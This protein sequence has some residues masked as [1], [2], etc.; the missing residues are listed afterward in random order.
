M[1]SII[2]INYNDLS[3]LDLAVKSVS[4]QK[5]ATVEH[6]IIDGGSTDGSVAYIQENKHLFSYCISEKD[7]GVYHAMNKGIQAA[8]GDYLF[9]LNAGDRFLNDAILQDFEIAAATKKDIYYGDVQ[10]IDIDGKDTFLATPKDLSFEFFF[11]RTIPHQAAFIKTSLFKK[12]GYYNESL[13]IVSD[14][15]FFILAI[16][17]HNVT[18]KHINKTIAYFDTTGLSNDPKNR[19][20]Y[21]AERIQVLEKHFPSFIRDYKELRDQ[22]SILNK[23]DFIKLN[24]LSKTQL[25]RKLTS[26]WLKIITK[27]VK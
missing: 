5:N 10:L 3:G 8:K 7:N 16:C 27:C 22:K 24:K 12:I 14:W 1:I 25:P 15:E 21:K 13:K 20:L 4:S 6:I 23:S 18:Y 9:F 17:K 26:L 11:R 19:S 2:T